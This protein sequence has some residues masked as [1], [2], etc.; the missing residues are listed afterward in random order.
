MLDLIAPNGV[1][2]HASDEAAPRLLMD[3][4][5]RAETPGRVVDPT[6]LTNAELRAM[7][8]GR[9]I[10]APKRATKAQLLALL[11]EVTP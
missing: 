6:K 3:G 1:T 2:V 5:A 9:G 10:D 7:C 4:W 11:G 8:E